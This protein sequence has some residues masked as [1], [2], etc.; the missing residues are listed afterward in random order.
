MVFSRGNGFGPTKAHADGEG[1]V[2]ELSRSRHSVDVTGQC[3]IG[4]LF[5]MHLA[6]STNAPICSSVHMNHHTSSRQCGK[7]NHTHSNTMPHPCHP[8]NMR[9][10]RHGTAGDDKTTPSQRQHSEPTV[11]EVDGHSLWAQMTRQSA[12]KVPSKQQLPK[13]AAQW[14]VYERYLGSKRRLWTY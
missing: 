9:Q 5:L 3:L 12:N 13:R 7:E 2:A 11:L 4:L 10:G 14:Q 6:V 1:S 8:R